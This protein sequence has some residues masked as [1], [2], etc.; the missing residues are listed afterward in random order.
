MAPH[1]ID[2]LYFFVLCSY[3]NPT[4]IHTHNETNEL[5]GPIFVPPLL[6]FA[7]HFKRIKDAGTDIR[8]ANLP[9]LYSRINPQDHGVLLFEQDCYF[10]KKFKK[11]ISTFK[12]TQAFEYLYSVVS[13]P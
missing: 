3:T 12:S 10:S 8:T 11:Q 5:T 6:C 13:R 9:S 2:D 7:S 1:E 4:Q